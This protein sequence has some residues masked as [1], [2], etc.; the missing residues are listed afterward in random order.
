MIFGLLAVFLWIGFSAMNFG[1]PAKLAERSAYFSPYY[2][3][4]FDV[5]PILTALLF[6]PLWLWAVTRKNVK[7]RQAVTNWAAGMTLV[8]AL[9]M[10][11]FLPW[12]DA[13]KSYRPVVARMEAAAPAEL[14]E[15]RDC[16][17]IDETAVLARVSWREYGSLPFEVGE[18]ACGYRLIQ[19]NADAAVPAGWREVWQGGR[20]RNKNERF[21]LLQRL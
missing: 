17:S 9:L 7:G 4:E 2:T 15:R 10:T 19:A 21:L 1:W 12:L 16:F 18:S 20:P 8:W 5:M 6:T 13:A 14:R 3:P 11:L